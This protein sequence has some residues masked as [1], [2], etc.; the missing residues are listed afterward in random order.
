MAQQIL[1][2]SPADA[3]VHGRTWQSVA[4][5]ITAIAQIV[6]A[7]LTV[8]LGV[9]QTVAERSASTSHPLVPAA[10]A[11][12]I[13]GV[14]YIYSLVAAIWQ[15]LPN[16]RSNPALLEAGWNIAGIYLINCLW[17][18]W[19]PLNGLDWISYGLVAVSLMLGVSAMMRLRLGKRMPVLTTRLVFAPL[20]L[21]TGW[22]TAA[23]VVNF[24]SVLVAG[25]YG[26]D[27]T[28]VGVSLGFLVALIVFAAII[29]RLT[30]SLAYSL[31]LV[32]ALFWI[33]M[34]NIF[35]DHQP[36]MVVTALAGIVVVAAICLV[37]LAQ[38]HELGRFRLKHI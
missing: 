38:N 18:I 4:I 9:G 1:T 6:C 2:Q 12:S 35:R 30:R 32:W 10:F 31:A 8:M 17:Q 37:T 7:P 14:L 23:S 24:T 19:V 21:M 5:L 26:L 11:F 36:M 28:Q 34:A 33:M 3:Q 16:Q 27:P 22:I 25:R 15:A 13:W 20:A 29:V